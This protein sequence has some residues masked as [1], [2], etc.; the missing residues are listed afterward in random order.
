[1]CAPW[2]IIVLLVS[3]F[4]VTKI[5][6]KLISILRFAFCRFVVPVKKKKG[7]KR[8]LDDSDEEKVELEEDF[9]IASDVGGQSGHDTDEVKYHCMGK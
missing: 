7:K 9:E 3:C 1:M 4:N 5:I 2:L 8:I 6:S